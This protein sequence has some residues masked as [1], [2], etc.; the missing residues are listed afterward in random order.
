[1]ERDKQLLPSA[2]SALDFVDGKPG[3]SLIL[4]RDAGLRTLAIWAAM[5]IAGS[6]KDTLKFAFAG[7][8][9]IETVVLFLAFYHRR[10]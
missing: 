2:R 4:A 9:G 5:T 10:R 3:S 8:L 6:K 7:A 1:M